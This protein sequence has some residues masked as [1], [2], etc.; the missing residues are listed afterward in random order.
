MEWLSVDR[1]NIPSGR[2]D[3][4]L[5]PSLLSETFIGIKVSDPIRRNWR[6][7]GDL[8][9]QFNGGFQGE[10]KFIPLKAQIALP[11]VTDLGS[12]H[13][14]FE[15][16]NYHKGLFV[17]VWK[18]GAKPFYTFYGNH[19]P[20]D[21]YVYSLELATPLEFLASGVITKLRFFAPETETGDHTMHLWS[22]EGDLLVSLEFPSSG[23][24]WN[25]L[26]LPVPYSVVSGAILRVSVNANA[27]F[28]LTNDISAF[29]NPANLVRIPEGRNGS[30][31][32]SLGSFPNN[33]GGD[34]D[35]YFVDVIFEPN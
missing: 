27:E 1:F 15:P 28:A 5:I 25:E 10:P 31:G 11:M 30:Y 34:G 22:D 9:Q 23:S 26:A 33:G 19:Q 24:G 13:L 16:V 7:A 18:W 17:E 3:P 32:F 21:V 14:R 6:K 29:V 35:Y 4:I 12:Y 20:S 8:W 2:F